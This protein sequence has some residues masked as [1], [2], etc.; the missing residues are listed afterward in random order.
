MMDWTDRHCRYFLRRLSPSVLLYTEMVTAAAINHG[1]VQ[2]LLGFDPSE[3]PLAIQLG[4][5]DPVLLAKAARASEIYGYQ[6]IN[7]NVGCPSDRVQSG[8]FGA[9]LMATPKLVADCVAAMKDAVSIPVTVKTRIGID[10]QDSYEF[11]RTFI[12][13]VSEHCESFAVHARKAVLAGLS[14][15]ENRKVPPLMYERV[16][17][18]KRDYPGLEIVLNGG[19]QT[20]DQVASH[21]EHVDGVMIG[22]AAYHDPYLLAQLEQRFLNPDFVLPS[23]SDIAL[24][25]LDYIENEVSRGCRLH[26]ITRHMLGLYTGQPGARRWRRALGEQACRPDAGPEVILRAV[27]DIQQAA[28]EGREGWPERSA[29]P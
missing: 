26:N 4:G 10:D 27:A 19:V 7:L 2:R 5:S 29:G 28:W 18:L 1:D 11:L 17:Q 14:P 23:R 21:L 24:S 8:S 25:M 22:R 15:R 13:L 3:L 6:E 20:A 16:Y 12:D 9:C